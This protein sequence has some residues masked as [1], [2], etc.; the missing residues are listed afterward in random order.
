M[1]TFLITWKSPNS[2][3]QFKAGKLF[4][5]WY[6]SGG[7]NNNP[8]GFERIGWCSLMQNGSGVSIVRANSLE[9]IWQVYGKWR[10]LGLE[11]DVQPAATMQEAS[12][13]FKDMT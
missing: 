13:W 10:K 12:D 9:K 5:D 6:E 8:D 2:E 4:V 7:P 1:Q 11:I 3:I